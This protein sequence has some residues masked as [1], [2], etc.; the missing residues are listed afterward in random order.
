M[1][2]LLDHSH[3]MSSF[4]SLKMKTNGTD[5]SSAGIVFGAKTDEAEKLKT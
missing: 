3:E 4:L 5:L 2:G 1:N